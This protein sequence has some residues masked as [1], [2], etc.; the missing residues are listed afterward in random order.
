MAH[1]SM[2]TVSHALLD[3]YFEYDCEREFCSTKYTFYHPM[4][5]GRFLV[6][7]FA[8]K[9]PFVTTATGVYSVIIYEDGS[10]IEPAKDKRFVQ[11]CSEMLQEGQA[12]TSK[13]FTAKD[14]SFLC[15][16]VKGLGQ[17]KPTHYNVTYLYNA[18]L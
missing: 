15:A 7:V 18:S 17:R 16:Y 11:L 1:G 2:E 5:I 12:W 10:I 6:S 13:D 4:Q 8:K 9:A 3:A 14:I